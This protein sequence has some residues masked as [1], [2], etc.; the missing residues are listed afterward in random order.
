[1][2]GINTFLHKGKVNQEENKIMWDWREI[3]DKIDQ[4]SKK[5]PRKTRLYSTWIELKRKNWI[6]F[7]VFAVQALI[8]LLLGKLIKR[9]WGNLNILRESRKENI[10]YLNNYKKKGRFC[11]IFKFQHQELMWS[12]NVKIGLWMIDIF[13]YDLIWQ[14]INLIHLFFYTNNLGLTWVYYK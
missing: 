12:K 1:M 13:W 9:N 3:K 2:N 4:I 11:S 10:I 8:P 7:C 6:L 5:Q 14:C